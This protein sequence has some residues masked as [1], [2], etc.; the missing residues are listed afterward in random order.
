MRASSGNCVPSKKR[1]S[2]E[3]AQGLSEEERYARL[4]AFTQKKDSLRLSA[5]LISALSGFHPY[6]NLPQTLMD[7]VYKSRVGQE[8]LRHDCS[9]LN[10]G[11]RSDDEILL[12]LANKAGTSTF[13][14]VQSALLVKNGSKRINTQQEAQLLKKSI[15]KEAKR[16]NKLNDAELK[17]LQDRVRHSVNTGYGTFHEEEALN[18]YERMCGWPVTERNEEIMCWPFIKVAPA[19]ATIDGAVGNS[20]ISTAND[21]LQP[22]AT[23]VVPSRKASPLYPL[24]AVAATSLEHTRKRPRE[25]KHESSS[26]KIERPFSSECVSKTNENRETVPRDYVNHEQTCDVPFVPASSIR[27][28]SSSEKGGKGMQEG[29][30]SDKMMARKDHC[31]SILDHTVNP[32]PFFSI[33]GAVDGMRE[34]LWCPTGTDANN[35][36]NANIKEPHSPGSE[37]W[38]LRPVVVECKH[39]MKRAILPPPLYDQIQ[40]IAYCFM[41]NTNEADIVQVVRKKEASKKKQTNTKPIYR[42]DSEAKM[43]PSSGMTTNGNVPAVHLKS[44]STPTLAAI[45]ISEHEPDASVAIIPETLKETAIDARDN[46]NAKIC[47]DVTRLSL[48]DPIMQHRRNWNEVVLPRLCSFVNA[49]YAVRSDDQKRYQLISS[50]TKTD[51]GHSKEAWEIL[52]SECQW[53]LTCDTAFR[54]L[55]VTG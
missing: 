34:E 24:A 39:R 41:Y 44:S 47:I 53:L 17:D 45:S 23:V 25:R 5:S 20:S 9:L 35:E 19:A 31:G 49:V 18:M 22:A 30:S 55:N 6:N 43:V 50:L 8:L 4:R 46:A 21:I 52:H 32:P 13:G 12:E 42:R 15:E 14:A 11:L 51:S 29:E 7:L 28:A 27:S 1:N 54:R 3:E 26:N 10:I 33:L 36:Y 38:L 2:H 40:V 37:E 16:S 48:D